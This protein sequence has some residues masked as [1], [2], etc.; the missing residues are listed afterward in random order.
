M[1]ELAEL[2]RSLK[3]DAPRF[4]VVFWPSTGTWGLCLFEGGAQLAV[5]DET[6][7]EAAWDSIKAQLQ[8]GEDLF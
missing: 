3:L 6:T 2:L 7:L 1:N 5:A 4:T 8:S